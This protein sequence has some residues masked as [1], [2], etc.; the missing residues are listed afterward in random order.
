MKAKYLG[1]CTDRT[2]FTY[3]MYEYR[4]H[5]YMVCDTHNGYAETLAQQHRAEQRRIDELI[6]N[7][8]VYG[9]YTGEAEK[10]ID[11]LLEYW[12]Y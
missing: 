7:S 1:S 9:E 11:K 3:L 8:P 2:G 12:G 6:G 10:A 4:G 5:E